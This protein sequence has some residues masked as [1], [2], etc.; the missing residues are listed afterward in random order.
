MTMVQSKMIE[1]SSQTAIAKLKRR[2]IGEIAA[3]TTLQRIIQNQV[4]QCDAAANPGME[5]TDLIRE[6]VAEVL[7]QKMLKALDRIVFE[8]CGAAACPE[9][10]AKQSDTA[11]VKA[12]E[13]E[14]SRF[15]KLLLTPIMAQGKPSQVVESDFF[16]TKLMTMYPDL[17]MEKHEYLA[18]SKGN[19]AGTDELVAEEKPRIG[20][21]FEEEKEGGWR[22]T[23]SS[24][25]RQGRDFATGYREE[26]HSFEDS[27]LIDDCSW[28]ADES[29]IEFELLRTDSATPPEEEDSSSA[30]LGARRKV[31]FNSRV[32][33]RK[34]PWTPKHMVS[35]LFY[36]E[37]EIDKFLDDYDKWEAYGHL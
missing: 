19:G 10:Q 32:T 8:A 21:H 4:L 37:D 33:I 7:D 17:F 2:V 36:S 29:T 15:D 16:S 28:A 30:Q 3:N 27:S 12:N 11:T 9:K 26:M 35:E 22:S 31:T 20:R 25:A 6:K 23:E 34:R 18:D 14:F 5:K 13:D 24:S 1:P